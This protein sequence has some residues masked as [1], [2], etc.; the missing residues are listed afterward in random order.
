[1][2]RKSHPL[3]HQASAH[4]KNSDSKTRTG[5]KVKNKVSKYMYCTFFSGKYIKE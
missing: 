1:M 2:T 4:I 5:E 3:S